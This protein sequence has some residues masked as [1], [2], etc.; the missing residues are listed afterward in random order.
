LRCSKCYTKS[1]AIFAIGLDLPTMASCCVHLARICWRLLSSSS[2]VSSSNCSSMVFFHLLQNGL[3]PNG[4]HRKW[5]SGFVFNGLLYIVNVHIVSKNGLCVFVGLSMGVP[6]KP[7]NVALGK[8][9][10]KCLGKAINKI[11]LA[12][13]GFI[14]NYYNVFSVRKFWISAA[15]FIRHKFLNGCKNHTTRSNSKQ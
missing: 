7:I 15:F 1:S 5:N 2:S 13:V 8:A 14:C 6:V 11:V 4:F 9:S 12:S 3:L 10:R